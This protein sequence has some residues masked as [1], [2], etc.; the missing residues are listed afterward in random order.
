VPLVGARRPTQIEDAFR[1]VG[2]SLTAAEVADIEAV[3]P[4]DAVAGSRYGEAQMRTLDSE[5]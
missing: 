2:V 1:T 3:V 5:R 4:A